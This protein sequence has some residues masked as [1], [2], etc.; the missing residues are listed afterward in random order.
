MRTA[1]AHVP[2]RAPLQTAAP[3]RAQA[4]APHAPAG[5]APMP[6]HDIS[7][8]PI[9]APVQRRAVPGGTNRTGLPDGLKAGLE[10][11]SGMSMDAVRVHYRSPEPARIAAHAFAR[12]TDIHLAPGQERHLPHEAWHVV[13][14]AQGRVRPTVDMIGTAVNDDA[15]LER[16][17]DRMGSASLAQGR[18]GA[19]APAPAGPLAA[20]VGDTVQ[21]EF[22]IGAGALKGTYKTKAGKDTNWLVDEVKRVI[23][24]DLGPGWIGDLR[25][26]A[27]KGEGPYSWNSTTEFL[28]D[29]LQR[30]AKVQKD[31]KTRPNFS[32]I[33]YKLAKVT[34]G[35]QTG[36]DQSGLSPS[37]DDLAMPHRFPYAGIELS[38]AL[39]ISGKEDD[40]DLKRWTGRLYNAT[41]ARR[42]LNLPH[43][44][45]K[46]EAQWYNKAVQDQLDELD[47][48]VG[49]IISAKKKG[50]TMTLHTPVVQRLLKAANNM[51]GNIP[52]YGPHSKINIPVSNRLHLHVEAPDDDM[53]E[54]D[55]WTAPMTPG[56]YEAGQMSPHRVPKGIA[57]DDDGE[58][59]IGTDGFGYPI[60]RIEGYDDL[61][62]RHGMGTTTIGSKALNWWET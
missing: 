30:Y 2:G 10:S 47:N 43:I 36:M 41:V 39:F 28:D 56:S 5:P 19:V 3:A 20:P 35:I 61:M 51:H 60:E 50:E 12:G 46:S 24:D 6:L 16:E 9:A 25:G 55:D 8:V 45:S 48:A 18:G 31:G 17:A 33:A 23:E 37:D 54:D 59:M 62:K 4:L 22:T 49:A 58:N 44:A 52:D 34:Y 40:N 7:R 21:G 15:G 57:H 32:S 29:M 27:A 53:L 38:T 42:K 26:W 13:Q 11:M 14:Q 1:R